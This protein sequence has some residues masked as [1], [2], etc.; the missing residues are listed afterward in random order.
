MFECTI[1]SVTFLANH[2]EAIAESI[3]DQ[4]IDHLLQ[5][6]LLVMID[7]GIGSV[8]IERLLLLQMLLLLRSA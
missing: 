1:V 3:T 4:K 8:R 2:A 5:I 7:D 6:A